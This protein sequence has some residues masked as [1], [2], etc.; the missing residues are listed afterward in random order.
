MA[1]N[2]PTYPE[3]KAPDAPKVRFLQKSVNIKHM[4]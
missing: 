4:Q 2:F 1:S 3:V